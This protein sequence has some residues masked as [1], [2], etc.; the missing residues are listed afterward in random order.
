MK[1]Q[2][3]IV[4]AWVAAIGIIVWSQ[5]QQ[6]AGVLPPAYRL[7]GAAVT[8]TFLL[9]LSMVPGAGPLAATFALAWTFGLL[10]RTSNATAGRPVPASFAPNPAHSP[11]TGKAVG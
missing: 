3:V 5:Q 1:S 7:G 2:R 8:Y 11:T 6:Q 4:G 9:V 10:W